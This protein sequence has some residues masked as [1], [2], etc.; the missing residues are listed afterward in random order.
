MV[1]VDREA[2]V[3]YKKYLDKYMSPDLSEV[4]ISKTNDDNL[5]LK[6]FHFDENKQ[7]N[8]KRFH[9]K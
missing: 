2:C 8:S 9:W 3:T 1:A 6:K 7:K 4:I 5:D